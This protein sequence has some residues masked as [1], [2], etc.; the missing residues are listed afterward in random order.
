MTKLLGKSVID[1][2][3]NVALNVLGIGNKQD[4]SDDLECDPLLYTAVQ[5]FTCDLY[6]CFSSS[7]FSWCNYWQALCKK[8]C[9]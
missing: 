6:W 7:Y 9:H 8:F 1:Q 2:Y 5:R 3:S 4:F